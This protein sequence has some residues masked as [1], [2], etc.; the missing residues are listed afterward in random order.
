[1]LNKEFFKGLDLTPDNELSAKLGAIEKIQ[2]Q[3]YVYE[4]DEPDGHFAYGE[5]A[6][7]KKFNDGTELSFIVKGSCTI[8]P[9]DFGEEGIKEMPHDEAVE[10]LLLEYY[11]DGVEYKIKDKEV[12]N[13]LIK[14]VSFI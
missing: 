14:Q 13:V 5:G 1:M 10:V 11:I 3:S 7:F 2:Q 12:I 4:Y 6:E 8:I 9:E